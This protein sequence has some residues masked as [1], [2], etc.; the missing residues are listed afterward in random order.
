MTKQTN[1]SLPKLKQIKQYLKKIGKT[2]K[3]LPFGSSMG[4]F[5]S[6]QVRQKMRSA[7][8]ALWQLQESLSKVLPGAGFFH[9]PEC[10]G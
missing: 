8:S 9:V 3:Y 5:L 7:K 10:F 1:E 6:R 2:E 4:V